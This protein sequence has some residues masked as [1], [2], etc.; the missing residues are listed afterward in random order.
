MT[1][2]MSSL[3]VTASSCSDWT[4]GRV[5]ANGSGVTSPTQ[6]PESVG[7]GSGRAMT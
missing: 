3:R 2:S 5:S 7:A 6:M 4:S 1:A